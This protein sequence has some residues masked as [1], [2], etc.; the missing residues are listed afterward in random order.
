MGGKG[1]SGVD[2]DGQIVRRMGETDGENE[3][4]AET[5]KKTSQKTWLH[6]FGRLSFSLL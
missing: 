2:S 6:Y 3:D 4:E 5:E 1:T